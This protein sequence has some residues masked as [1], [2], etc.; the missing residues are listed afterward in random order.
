[1]KSLLLIVALLA[2][3][4]LLA[5]ES[6]DDGD[7]VTRPN[8]HPAY[9]LFHKGTC[10]FRNGDFD[11]S[12]EFWLQLSALDN[13]PPELQEMHTDSL[14]NLGYLLFHGRGVPKDEVRAV[15]YW[16]KA[17]L[18][19]HTEAEYHLCYAYGNRKVTTYQP[20]LARRHCERARMSYQAIEQPDN[21]D[22]QMLD[23]IRAYL[24]QL[25]ETR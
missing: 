18:S 3:S 23:Q 22:K 17:S 20:D 10:H 14:N 4:A 12:Y 19:G 11:K 1:M 16:R 25:E 6:C 24:T 13:L 7:V 8:P 21:D 15:E 9:V 2:P 5:K